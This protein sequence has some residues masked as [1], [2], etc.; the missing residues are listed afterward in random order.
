MNILTNNFMNTTMST[1][2]ASMFMGRGRKRKL[3][4]N[5]KPITSTMALKV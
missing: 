3:L 2:S 5:K 1:W 4:R